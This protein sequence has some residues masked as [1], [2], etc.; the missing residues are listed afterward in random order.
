M[1]ADV[2]ITDDYDRMSKN[3]YSKIQVKIFYIIVEY[4]D[5]LVSPFPS[6]LVKCKQ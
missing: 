6:T 1:W 4:G 3:I 2:Y 5:I